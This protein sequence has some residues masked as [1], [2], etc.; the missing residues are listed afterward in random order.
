MKFCSDTCRNRWNWLHN[1]ARLR[2]SPRVNDPLPNREC[3]QCGNTFTCLRHDLPGQR[4][5]K[6]YCSIECRNRWWNGGQILTAGQVVNYHALPPELGD[7][8]RLIRR[9]RQSMKSMKEAS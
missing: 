9:A 5:A 7:I 2:I 6:R 1:G 8:A 4:T 3:I